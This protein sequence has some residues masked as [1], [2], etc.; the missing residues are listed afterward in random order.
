MNNLLEIHY[1]DVSCGARQ[2]SGVNESD[3]DAF[4]LLV[5]GKDMSY[6]GDD[7]S[8]KRGYT[9]IF[10][11]NFTGNGK[12]IAALIKKHKLGAIQATGWKINPNS[13]NR[14]NIWTWRYNGKVPAAWKKLKGPDE[15][16][17]DIAFEDNRGWW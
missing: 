15:D 12:K 17:S 4:K 5:A 6:A 11:D 7:E 13:R 8:F 1:T 16:N 14:I 10:S 2:L 9:Y 3:L